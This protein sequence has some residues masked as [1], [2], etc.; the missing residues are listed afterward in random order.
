M[1]RL[2][3]KP[4]LNRQFQI[5]LVRLNVLLFCL[6]CFGCFHKQS[7]LP[8]QLNSNLIDSFP[9]AIIRSNS[10]VVFLHESQSIEKHIG[11]NWV[12][13]EESNRDKF[14]W[15]QIQSLPASIRI[16]F[17][18]RFDR[19]I[20]LKFLDINRNADWMNLEMMLNGQSVP[21]L[22]HSRQSDGLIEFY[23]PCKMQQAGE[24]TLTLNRISSNDSNVI[25]SPALALHSFTIS[26][27]AAIEAPITIDNQIRPSILLSSPVSVDFVIRNKGDCILEFDYSFIFDASLNNKLLHQSLL[28]SLRKQSSLTVDF[29]E[30]I[31]FQD[32]DFSS[33]G[34]SKKR[35]VLD[36]PIDAPMILSL[37][38]RD[39]SI[40]SNSP[41]FLALSE[42]HLYP[43]IR[44]AQS[45]STSL[46]SDY[47]V[48]MLGNIGANTLPVY[49][50]DLGLTP[51]I[52]KLAQ[53]STLFLDAFTPTN[54]SFPNILSLFTSQLAAH[55]GFYSQP[56]SRLSCPLIL[57]VPFKIA[58]YAI[59]NVVPSS[60]ASQEFFKQFPNTERTYL[61]DS[62]DESHTELLDQIRSCLLSPK[63]KSRPLFCFIH[64]PNDL[65]SHDKKARPFPLSAY[66]H[67]PISIT[68]MV[69]PIQERQEIEKKLAGETDIRLLLSNQ[70]F[71]NYRIDRSIGLIL[72]TFLQLRKQTN[73]RI[74]ITSDHGLITSNDP[75]ILS[76]DSLSQQVIHVP[77]LIN[78]SFSNPHS[79]M[80]VERPFPQVLSSGILLRLL[81]SESNTIEPS[82]LT[83]IVANR[84]DSFFTE[85][86]TRRILAL[87]R[88]SWKIIHCF[89]NP[90]YRIS[91]TN[92]F[93]LNKE[94]NEIRSRAS[95]EPTIRDEMFM[96]I[97][98]FTKDNRVY[99]SPEPS[100]IDDGRSF[101][102]SLK[103]L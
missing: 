2:L 38:Y 101:L 97:Q 27:G 90:Y 4:I 25:S 15:P 52:D 14:P 24:N 77:L 46:G 11:Q 84:P 23:L 7:V 43:K 55:H 96:E 86:S 102:T 53:Q 80:L 60:L 44:K 78:T 10:T 72:K 98:E 79:P 99:P 69:S 76:S 33:K 100:I 61:Y 21:R 19:R 57:N 39:F 71:N 95:I 32:I 28:V 1:T 54:A 70:D 73:L 85:H 94:P 92:L 45:S 64:L 20:Q 49:G 67:S 6:F 35:I 37:S 59:V 50:Y 40:T 91:V 56:E 62:S 74:L 58:G 17:K 18:E 13:T 42:L 87:R 31:E 36:V 89:S 88:D 47:L 30:S 93:D 51:V 34:W 83:D 75:N 8:V 82:L 12:F 29:S 26:D 22:D 16:I 3:L 41:V 48:I 63:T 103:Y 9:N 5:L 65:T 68:R 81:N 66:S